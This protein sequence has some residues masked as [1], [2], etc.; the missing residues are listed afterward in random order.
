M[1][2]KTRCKPDY[3]PD[4]EVVEYP[5]DVLER[6][7]AKAEIASMQIRTGELEHI[8]LEDLARELGVDFK[9]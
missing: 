7:E 1:L 3:P 4:I 9:R 8:S 5:P 6:L 2:T